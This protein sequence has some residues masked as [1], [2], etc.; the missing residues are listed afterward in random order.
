MIRLIVTA[1]DFGISLEVNEAIER[2]H[3]YGM[4]SAASLMVGAEA[5]ADAIARARQ[6]PR[7][8]VGLHLTLVDG[9]PLLPAKDVAALIDETQEFLSDPLHAGLRFSFSRTARRQLKAEIEAQ[10]SAFHATGLKLD[11]VNSHHHMHL[12]PLVLDAIIESGNRHGMKAMRVPFEPPPLGFFSPDGTS[13]GGLLSWFALLPWVALLKRRLRRA[14]LR[15]NDRLLGLSAS[16]RM[17]EA[18]VLR[19]L[20]RLQSGITEIYFHPIT[21]RLVESEQSA[22]PRPID[23]E[24]AALTSTRVL[25]QV[26]RQQLV[27]LGFGDLT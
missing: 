26:H 17:D 2:A 6:M 10:F 5:S 4:L 23:D 7:L 19:Y 12:H 22:G 1:D 8:R 14:G 16:G 20:S 21:P 25:T 11:H 27:P 3:R 15:F 24:L 13:L 9:R 18:R